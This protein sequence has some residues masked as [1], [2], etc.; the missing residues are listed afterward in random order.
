MIFSKMKMRNA[1]GR[2]VGQEAATPPVTHPPPTHQRER[3]RRAITRLTI[4]TMMYSI[5]LL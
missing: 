2:L 4:P 3:A 1:L 5:I